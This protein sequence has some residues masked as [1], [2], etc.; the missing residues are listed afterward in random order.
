VEVGTSK[1]WEWVRVTQ[2]ALQAAASG[3]YALGPDE[4]EEMNKMNTGWEGRGIK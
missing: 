3:V 1:P 2:Y 4:E